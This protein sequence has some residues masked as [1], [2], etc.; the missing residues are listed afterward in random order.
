MI[1]EVFFERFCRKDTGLTCF[2][3]NFVHMFFDI[4]AYFLTRYTFTVGDFHENIH[5]TIDLQKHQF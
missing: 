4:F 1:F 2:F 5:K 3:V